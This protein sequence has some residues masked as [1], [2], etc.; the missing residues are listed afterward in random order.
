MAHCEPWRGATVI[1]G[2]LVVVAA[3]VNDGGLLLTFAEELQARDALA[4]FLI[5]C[6]Y[7]FFAR[8]DGPR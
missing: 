5:P 1:I 4:L 2:I 3:T 8:K 7:V 6:L